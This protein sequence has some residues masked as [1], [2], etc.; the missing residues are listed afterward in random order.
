MKL[1][2]RSAWLFVLLGLG[3]FLGFLFQAFIIANVVV[4]IATIFLLFWRLIL[5]VHQAIYWGA[6]IVLAVGLAF[7]HLFQDI[8][9]EDP[10]T[11]T[12]SNSVLKDINY[13]RI[14]LQLAGDEASARTSL[15]SGLRS[16][17]VSVY[18]AK[19][20]E[21]AYL[22]IDE[23]LRSHQIP[24]PDAL[25]HFLFGDEAQAARLSWRTRL[26]QLAAWPGRWLHHWTGRDKVEYYRAMEETLTFMETLM[27]IKHGDNYF[28]L[29]D[30]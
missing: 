30:H 24:L 8:E 9:Y 22:T 21:A 27:E 29:T 2:R 25:F 1:S 4:P 11:R 6:V 16:M 14:S 18:A 10:P 19:Q 23:A 12:S 17:L 26:R 15:K 13:W 20:P 5:S 7:H 28:D 3:L